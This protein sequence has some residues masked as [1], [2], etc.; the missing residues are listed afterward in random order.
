MMEI[1]RGPFTT[2]V[3]LDF[4]DTA[5]VTFGLNEQADIN[6]MVR[7]R[8]FDVLAWTQD[9]KTI[10]PEGEP[11]VFFI[12]DTIAWNMFLAAFEIYAKDKQG[13][14]TWRQKPSMEKHCS[15]SD[16]NKYFVYCRLHIDDK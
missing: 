1:N 2:E 7:D 8:K 16:C 9:G 14:I 15:C 5:E 10:K 12:T 3:M 13:R 4:I 11:A 6:Q